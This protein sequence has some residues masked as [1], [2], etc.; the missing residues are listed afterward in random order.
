M[1]VDSILIA[2]GTDVSRQATLAEAAVAVAA[3]AD[4]AVELV[5]VYSREE[6]ET[7][8]EELNYDTETPPSPDDLAD[9]HRGLR[10]AVDV[11]EAADV[12]YATHG[13]VGDYAEKVVSM[14][15]DLEVDRV[16]I[17]GRERSPAGKAL[18]GSTSQDVLINAPCPVTY[19]RHGVDV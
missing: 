18:F 7:V 15:T 10:D 9:R 19:V 4:A 5:H 12:E 8:T 1:P 16:Y 6:Y 11:L 14:A 2:V 13:V 3:P 17:G